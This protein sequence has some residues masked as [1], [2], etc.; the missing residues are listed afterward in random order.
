MNDDLIT[1][2]NIKRALKKKGFA[3]LLLIF[4]LPMA[5]PL[6]YPPGFTSILSIP[7]LL[8]A[9]QLLNQYPEPYLPH[10]ICAKGFK[11]ETLRH[12][13]KKAGPVFFKIE[14]FL[15][16]RLEGVVDG[17]FKYVYFGAILIN[18]IFIILPLMFANALPSLGIVLIALGMIKKDGLF[19]ICGIIVSFISWLVAISVIYFGA[20]VVTK[21]LGFI[22]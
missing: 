3:I 2:Y 12:F 16:P 19:I 11:R 8:F 20:Q 22:I 14:K 13:I 4:A 7:I 5:V 9:Y 1:I 10:F 6:P 17:K 15:K 21:F 18:G